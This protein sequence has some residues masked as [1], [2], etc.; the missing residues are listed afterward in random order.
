MPNGTD[1]FAFLAR[2]H[3]GIQRHVS[4]K[5]VGVMGARFWQGDDCDVYSVEDDHDASAQDAA[6]AYFATHHEYAKRDELAVSIYL[7]LG[8]ESPRNRVG[9][10]FPPMSSDHTF[11]VV[12]SHKRTWVEKQ[13]AGLVSFLGM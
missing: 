5:S 1:E 7:Y 12:V 6:L 13:I 8:Y 3:P 2:Y 10:I 9:L 4:G 11:K